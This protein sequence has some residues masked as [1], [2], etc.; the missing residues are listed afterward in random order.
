M[1]VCLKCQNLFSKKH[2]STATNC[3][4]HD[5][6]TKSPEFKLQCQM[7]TSKKLHHIVSAQTSTP[8]HK[9]QKSHTKLPAL[10]QPLQIA[11][12]RTATPNNLSAKSR[13]KLPDYLRPMFRAYLLAS[14]QLHQLPRAQRTVRNYMYLN[15]CTTATSL[16][17]LR[18][19]LAH[20]QSR[21][22]V[23]LLR[24]FSSLIS[25]FLSTVLKMVASSS[26]ALV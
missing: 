2:E 22:I 7:P 17:Q 20:K 9:R 26:S 11:S 4:H 6:N 23:S 25:S 10:K 15:S 14:K 24:Y 13:A 8:S 12:T 1:C 21:S 18:K 5:S 19:T 16:K 3:L